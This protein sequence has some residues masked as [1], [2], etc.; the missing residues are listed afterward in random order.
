MKSRKD[1]DYAL[2]IARLRELQLASSRQR[3]AALQAD[4]AGAGRL[5]ADARQTTEGHVCLAQ[6]SMD[7]GTTVDK[8]LNGRAAIAHVLQLERHAEQAA[9]QAQDE[10]DAHVASLKHA[11]AQAESARRMLE[12]QRKRSRTM[13]AERQ[14][15]AMETLLLHRRKPT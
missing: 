3:Q 10:R 12:R 4:V 6:A 14:Q 11:M 5:L 7:H 2:T 13:R 15:M 9:L 8:L 1:V